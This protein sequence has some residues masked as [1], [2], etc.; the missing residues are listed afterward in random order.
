MFEQ[1]QIVT[2]Y[3]CV[4]VSRKLQNAVKL[5]HNNYV[6]YFFL[7]GALCPGRATHKCNAEAACHMA[8]QCL[9]FTFRR[10]FR[11][12]RSRTATTQNLLFRAKVI[13]ASTG[14]SLTFDLA[15]GN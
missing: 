12:G 1:L 9:S 7:A 2:I 8:K 14:Q 11:Q 5:N 4:C 6:N 10:N 3:M 15:F 13:T